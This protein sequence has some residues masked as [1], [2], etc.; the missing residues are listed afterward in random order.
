MTKVLYRNKDNAQ[1]AVDNNQGYCP[2]KLGH[3]PD[4]K[5]MCK[6]FRDWIKEGYK[7]YCECGLYEAVND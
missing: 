5:C 7:G 4:H 6:Q 3:I 1:E 2:C